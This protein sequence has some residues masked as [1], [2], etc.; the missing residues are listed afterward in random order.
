MS[1]II[2]Q[3]VKERL[4]AL[5]VDVAVSIGEVTYSKDDLISHV[6]KDDEIGRQISNIQ[7]NFLQDLAKGNLYGENID[8]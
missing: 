2:K 1:D 6:Q 4:K 3:L 5:P 7:I 8:N